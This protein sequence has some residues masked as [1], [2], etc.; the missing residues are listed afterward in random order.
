MLR[1]L[2]IAPPR[3]QNRNRRCRLQSPAPLDLPRDRKRQPFRQSDR[4][5]VGWRWTTSSSWTCREQTRRRLQRVIST[6]DSL[7]SICE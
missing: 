4:T 1:S 6:K 3:Q 5:P 2:A 7:Q